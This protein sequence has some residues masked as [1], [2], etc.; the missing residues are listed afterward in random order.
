[1]RREVCEPLGQRLG[2][3]LLLLGVIAVI[4][5]V[6][7]ATQRFNDETFAFVSGALFV[8]VPLLGFL[9]LCGFIVLKLT[10]RRSEPPQQMTIPPIIMQMPGQP[11]LPYYGGN[12]HRD[13]YTTSGRRDWTVIG[14]GDDGD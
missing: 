11:Q 4:V 8:G 13:T 2:R 1:M 6:V 5:F 12:G 3:F 9:T 10:T 14:N 7:V